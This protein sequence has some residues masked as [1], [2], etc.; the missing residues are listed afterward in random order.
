MKRVWAL[1]ICCGLVLLLA[2]NSYAQTLRPEF[3]Q[4][5]SVSIGA[6]VGTNTL[7]ISGYQSP[8]ATI[9]LKTKDGVFL[10]ST[11]ADA[12]GYFS[13]SEV[14]INSTELTYCFQA[15]DF[16]RVGI[17]EACIT[18]PGP[19]T[20]NVTYSDVFLPP[21]IAISKKIINEGENAVIYG[22]SMPGA[23]V[24]LNISGQIVTVTADAT[25][26]YTYTY[27]NVPE[28]TFTISATATLEDKDSLDPTNN[29]ILEARSIPEQITD[30]V[31]KIPDEVE[32][33]IPRPVFDL[34]PFF[35]LALAFLVAIGILLYKLKFRLWVIFIDFLRRR[36][37]MHHDWFLD[38]W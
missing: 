15:M 17:S 2:V 20:G 8:Y 30:I 32:K 7:T 16:K 38:R 24:H 35:L 36:K 21:T 1:I 28:G 4:S 3:S 34:W 29:V 11:T 19:I 33:R 12:N 13:I 18:I 26:F 10:A 37:K 25:G 9:I 22:Y 23:K 27:E 14:L 5:G 6:T 31:D